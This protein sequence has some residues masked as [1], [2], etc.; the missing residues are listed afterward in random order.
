MQTI[1][2][3]ESIFNGK[4]ARSNCKSVGGVEPTLRPRV[5]ASRPCSLLDNAHLP[6]LETANVSQLGEPTPPGGALCFSSTW[7]ATDQDGSMS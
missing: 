2:F 1:R 7:G 5:V 6:N 4:R 3:N